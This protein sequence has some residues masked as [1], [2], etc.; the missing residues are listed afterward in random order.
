MLVPVLCNPGFNY[1]STFLLSLNEVYLK[2]NCEIISKIIH[3][4]VYS[5]YLVEQ[6]CKGNFYEYPQYIIL[7]RNEKIYNIFH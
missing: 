6:S 2:D 4:N 7:C 1:S 3:K 5:G